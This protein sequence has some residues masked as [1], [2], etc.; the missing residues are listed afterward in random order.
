MTVRTTDLGGTDWSNGDVLTSADQND[1]FGAVTL[2]RKIFASLTGST[3]TSTSTALENV[4]SSSFTLSALNGLIL[5]IRFKCELKTS[6]VNDAVTAILKISGTN[7]GDL[8]TKRGWVTFKSTSDE[9]HVPYLTSVAPTPG[10]EDAGIVT[11]STTDKVH[12]ND[13]GPALKL[14]DATTTFQVQFGTANGATTATISEIEIDVTYVER[15]KD[16]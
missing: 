13:M 14:L 2:H 8:Y 15:F 5:S 10:N 9:T 12:V 7:L 6:N 4:N 3:D 11:N 1:T 16:D